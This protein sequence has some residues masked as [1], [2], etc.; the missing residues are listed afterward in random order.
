MRSGLGVASTVREWI[1]EERGKKIEDASDA[2][3]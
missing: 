3:N 2:T 1:W